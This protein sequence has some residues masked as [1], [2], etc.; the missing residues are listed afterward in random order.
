[1]SILW[2]VDTRRVARK[3]IDFC[4]LAGSVVASS[5]ASSTSLQDIYVANAMMHPLRSW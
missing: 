1:M 4:R 5:K 2:F 3:E